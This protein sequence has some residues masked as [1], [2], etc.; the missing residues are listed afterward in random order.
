MNTA[1]DFF[2]NLYMVECTHDSLYIYQNF[3]PVHE[4]K[5]AQLVAV[6]ILVEIHSAIKSMAPPKALGLDAI[7]VGFYK[8]QW[9]VINQSLLQFIQP[10]FE[11]KHSMV[12]INK[13]SIA[14]IAKVL[15]PKRVGQFCLIV[16]YNVSYKIM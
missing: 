8:K 4:S 14:L 3:D 5:H 15:G 16:L 6:P 1:M 13:A 9:N 11:L 10:I 12:G 2:K 7:Q